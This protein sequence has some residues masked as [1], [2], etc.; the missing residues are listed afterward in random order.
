M[1]HRSI[2]TKIWDDNWFSNVDPIEKLLFIYLFTNSRATLCGIYELPLK[3]MSVETGIE[4]EMILK[5][6]GRFQESEKILYYKGYVSLKNSEKYQSD[7]PSIKIAIQSEKS[8]IPQDILQEVY[9]VWG[10]CGEG[11][12]TVPYR[13]EKSRVEKSSILSVSEKILEEWW[14]EYPSTKRNVKKDMAFKKLTAGID[15]VE[16]AKRVQKLKDQKAKDKK[17]LGGFIPNMSTYLNQERWDMD[18]EGEVRKANFVSNDS[19]KILN[20]MKY[21]MTSSK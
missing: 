13:V 15:E 14:N 8:L 4:K 10:G 5:I 3:T 7:S 6:M 19:E 18:I 16:L 1:K 11:V 9:R 20:A 2:E 21:K 17:W 12:D